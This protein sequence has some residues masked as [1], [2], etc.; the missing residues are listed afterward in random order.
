MLNLNLGPTHLALLG[1]IVD[2]DTVHLTITA[3]S[4]RGLLGGLLGGLL[5]GLAGGGGL[6]RGSAAVHRSA[7]KN[8]LSAEASRLTQAAKK[9]GLTQGRGYLIPLQ[10]STTRRT[11]AVQALPRVPSGICTVLDRP[12]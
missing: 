7:D 12:E 2:L 5:C 4:N 8:T 10:V 3:D 11:A 6:F 9:T 1:L